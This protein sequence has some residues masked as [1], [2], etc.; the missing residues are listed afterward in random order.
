M[1]QN[2]NVTTLQGTC[3]LLQRTLPY[4]E[5]SASDPAGSKPEVTGEELAK[6][7]LRSIPKVVSAGGSTVESSWE[8]VSRAQQ[9]SLCP[10]P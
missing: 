4:L 3:K 5:G 10:A 7:P 2:G 6:W 9:R 8:Q 1:R